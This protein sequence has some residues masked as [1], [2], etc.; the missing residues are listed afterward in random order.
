MKN[1]ETTADSKLTLSNGDTQVSVDLYSEKGADLINALYVKLGAQFQWMYQPTWLGRPIIQ[2]PQDIVAVQELI[3]KLKP[4][5]IIECG[6]ACG[7]SVVLS[8]SICELLGKGKVIGVDIE[9]RPHN[10]EAIEAHVLSNRIELIESSSIDE[11][12]VAVLR[13]RAAKAETVLVILDS[14]H[15]YAHVRRELEAYS[16]IV[17]PGS[18]L[19]AMDGAQTLVADIPRAKP[20]WKLDDPLTAIHEFL[21]AHPEYEI[22]PHYTRFGVTSNTDGFLK[23]KN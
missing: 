18:Y 19:I 17:T 14:N 12:T 1:F 21:K 23:R 3:W 4:D 8:A 15:T 2:F 6:V 20:E 16:Q 9:I 10:R 22:D 7:G 11:T 5:L 13:Q